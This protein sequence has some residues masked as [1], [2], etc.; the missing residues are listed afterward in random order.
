MEVVTQSAV[1]IIIRYF[2]LSLLPAKRSSMPGTTTD[3]RAVAP[4][5]DRSP[6]SVAEPPRPLALGQ[7][8]VN[9]L[10]PSVVS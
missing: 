10:H 7:V 5:T 2:S 9:D 3:P 6:W 8:G 4:Q 1:T